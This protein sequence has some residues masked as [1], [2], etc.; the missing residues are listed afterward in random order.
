MTKFPIRVCICTELHEHKA[1]LG[2]VHT[3]LL[4]LCT[5]DGMGVQGKTN[6]KKAFRTFPSGAPAVVQAAVAVQV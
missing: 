1:K 5:W 6:L 2:K 3:R 4:T